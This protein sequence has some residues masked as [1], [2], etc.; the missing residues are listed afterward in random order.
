MSRLNY[1][2]I[3]EQKSFYTDEISA[4]S[5]PNTPNSLN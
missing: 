3:L 1:V 2:S 4:S 5:S